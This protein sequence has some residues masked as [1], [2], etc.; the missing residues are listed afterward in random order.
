MSAHEFFYDSIQLPIAFSAFDPQVPT[1]LNI[2]KAI[3]ASFLDNLRIL[4]LNITNLLAAA[5]LS[6]NRLI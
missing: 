4:I 6:P 1:K 5:G 2:I 3:G